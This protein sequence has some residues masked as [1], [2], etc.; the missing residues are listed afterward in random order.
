PEHGIA[1]RNYCQVL[2][3]TQRSEEAI[4][5]VVR[6]LDSTLSADMSIEY[7]AGPWEFW[8]TSGEPFSVDRRQRVVATPGPVIRFP[9]A[10]PAGTRQLRFDA[11]PR[12]VWSAG[13]PQISYRVAGKLEPQSIRWDEV[14]ANQIEFSGS[15]M[16]TLGDAD[17]WWILNVPESLVGEPL[18]GEVAIPVGGTPHWIQEAILSPGALG[19]LQDHAQSISAATWAK[20]GEARLDGLQ[21]RS[22]NV[23]AGGSRIGQA[24]LHS[25]GSHGLT[26]ELERT[27]LDVKADSIRVALPEAAG[28][29]IH[30]EQIRIVQEGAM[31]MGLQPTAEGCRPIGD[32]TWITED[33]KA[34]L[35]FALDGTLG[36]IRSV[37]F[38]G[39]VQ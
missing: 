21:F 35:T 39:N 5:A 22:V 15:R 30:F 27:D 16:K 12:S 4:A 6:H 31:L 19:Y 13:L 28:V 25:Q 1:A 3:D 11:P 33:A 2:Q 14:K 29:R 26:F 23:E 18:E 17:P 20:L 34:S 10:V 32:D 8:W 37:A 38:K 9:F 24:P 36:A 7:G